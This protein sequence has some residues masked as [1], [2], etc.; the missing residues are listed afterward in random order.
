MPA[1]SITVTIA[2]DWNVTLVGKPI[3]ASFTTQV[4][5]GTVLLDII[6]KVADEDPEG[7]FNRYVSTYHGSLMGY[8]VT[9]FNGTEQVRYNRWKQEPI[10][11]SEQQPSIRISIPPRILTIKYYDKP[12]KS[13][14][15]KRRLEDRF[16]DV[17]SAFTFCF[18]YFP[19]ID[20]HTY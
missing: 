4:T 6:N 10:T 5:D 11:R 2:L 1:S 8:S 20:V 7:P 12:F 18:S 14:S 13:I 16:S 9:A 15:K 17:L 3:P 19:T